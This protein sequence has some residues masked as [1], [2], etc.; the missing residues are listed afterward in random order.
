MG[1]KLVA[2][3]MP[4]GLISWI[5]QCIIGG[6][7]A[8]KFRRCCLIGLVYLSG[9]LDRAELSP[10]PVLPERVQ[11]NKKLVSVHLNDWVIEV[12]KKM[13]LDKLDT[14]MGSAVD[15]LATLGAIALLKAMGKIREGKEL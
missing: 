10:R 14:S 2:L 6:S 11:R 8:D 4:E 9:G 3:K 7:R 13:V 12:A 15:S 5:D 1:L